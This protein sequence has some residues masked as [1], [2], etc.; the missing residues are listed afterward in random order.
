MRLFIALAMVAAA[1][2]ACPVAVAADAPDNMLTLAPGTVV[3]PPDQHT[4]SFLIVNSGQPATI[5]VTTSDSWVAVAEHG[6][7]LD[8]GQRHTFAGTVTIPQGADAGDHLTLV[9]FSVLPP[10]STA[11]TITITRALASRVVIATGGTIVHGVHVYG[12]TVPAIADSW[13]APKVHMT[14]SNAGNVHEVV[15][16][17][18]FGQVLVL[19][20]S[21][22]VLTLT[23]AQHPFIGMGHITAGGT[24]A[25]TL[26]LPWRIALGLLGLLSG[27]ALFLSIRR[28]PRRVRP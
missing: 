1:G 10:A 21:S 8:T 24:T 4:V 18:P 3:V 19:R 12:L 9:N 22:K 2:L 27:I 15:D 5:T 23:W 25:S 26:F 28:S 11:A 14:V 6:Y 16:V 17:A 7:S 20:D 13:E